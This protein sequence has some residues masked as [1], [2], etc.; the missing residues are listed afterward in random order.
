MPPSGLMTHVS[1]T[2]RDSALPRRARFRV[3]RPRRLL[4]AG[5][6]LAAATGFVGVLAGSGSTSAGDARPVISDEFVVGHGLA[7]WPAATLQDWVSYSDQVSLI[8]VV[9]DERIPSKDLQ[10]DGGYEGRMIRLR[11]ERTL[12]T[13]PSAPEIQGT[14]EMLAYGWLTTDGVRRPF[15]VDGGVWPEVGRKYVAPLVRTDEGRWAMLSSTAIVKLDDARAAGTVDG[16]E[17]SLAIRAVRGHA[18][19][20]VGALVA[21]TPRSPVAEKY[22]H[23]PPDARWQAV[24][25]ENGP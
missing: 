18:L 9:G 2:P 19:P 12:W 3:R 13:R 15:T 6:L 11:V 4:I 8:S 20:E 17:P 25:Q 5:C 24:D 21:G 7:R 14:L 23:L 10:L 1:A 16:G 22:A